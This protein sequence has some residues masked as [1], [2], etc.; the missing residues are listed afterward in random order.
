MFV[1]LQESR[2]QIDEIDSRIVELFQKRMDVASNVADYKIATGKPVFD[3]DRENEK[4]A[5]LTGMVE[6]EFDKKCVAELFAQIMAMSRKLQYQKLE[7][8]AADS[9][10]EP[11]DVIDR[12]PTNNVK[13]VY[14]G[15]PGA[16]S[17][18]AML[19]YFGS[20]TDCINVKTFRDAMELVS[21]GD[22]DYAVIPIDNS[23]AGIVSDTYDLLK[24]YNNYIVGETFVKINHCLLAKPGTD[25]SD[26]RKV[27]SHPQGLMQCARYLDEHKE[28][29]RESYLNTAMSA[30]KIAEED[31]CTQAAIASAVC[32][33]EYGLKILEEGINSAAGNTTRFVIVSRKR[34]F[35]RNA[36][37]VSICFEIPHRAGSLY[38]VIS[39]IMFNG[40]NMTKIESRP[41]PEH[42]WEFRFYVDFEGN[43]ADAGVRNALR[44]IAEESNDLKLLGNY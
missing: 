8:R 10:L 12:V 27:Y 9:R 41:I 14:Q 34:E 17:H 37:K 26:I 32:A 33:K 21:K 3:R 42:N 23:S 44:G 13:V 16:Y 29:E 1:D 35:V 40:L 25:I 11:Y 38:S 28:W 20:D 7:N 6:G 15:V 39:N 43:L 4:I 18:E 2:K 22:A 30:R 19:N 31:D 36:S 24:E 5:A